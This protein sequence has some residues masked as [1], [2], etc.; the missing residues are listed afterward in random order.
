M[1]PVVPA[2]DSR[3]AQGDVVL[4]GVLAVKADSGLRLGKGAV[5]VLRAWRGIPGLHV[6]TGQ[7]HDLAVRQI[8]G[9]RHD[10][11]RRG[12]PSA[13][14]GL[15]VRNR[16]RSDHLGGA[17]DA[18]SERVLAEYRLVEHVV[19]AVRWLILVHGDLLQDDL[20]L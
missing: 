12:V 6:L 3:P 9:G 18:A 8:P 4:L 5:A 16:N 7:L 2:L 13:V 11:A 17:E 1:A 15:D 14:V 20:A 10:D 19:D